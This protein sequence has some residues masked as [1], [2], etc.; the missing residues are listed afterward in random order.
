[1]HENGTFWPT[2]F[3]IGTTL[4]S[5]TLAAGLHHLRFSP[6][7]S[8]VLGG[9]TPAAIILA[10]ATM[11]ESQASVGGFALLVGTLFAAAILTFGIPAAALATILSVQLSRDPD[12]LS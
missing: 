1:M 3:L 7:L 5:A 4:T 11:L 9:V 10:V 12:E 6:L 2:V 8:G